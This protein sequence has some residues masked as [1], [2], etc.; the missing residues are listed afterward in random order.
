ME[1]TL[2]S[3]TSRFKAWLVDFAIVGVPAIIAGVLVALTTKPNASQGQPEI[4]FVAL[5]VMILVGIYSLIIIVIQILKLHKQ[6][7]TIGKQF[8]KVRIVKIADGTN[9]GIITNVVMRAI[10]PGLIGSIPMVGSVFA[11]VD[12]LF[13]FREDKRCI[14]DLIAGT[15]VVDA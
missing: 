8:A 1:G 5:A 10:V 2:A 4:S 6:G 3:R 9:G 14:H 15:R 12:I 11:L 13:I 7:Q